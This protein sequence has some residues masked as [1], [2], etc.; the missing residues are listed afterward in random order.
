M[1]SPVAQRPAAASVSV[2][3]TPNRAVSPPPVRPTSPLPFQLRTKKK[4]IFFWLLLHI[5]FFR[6]V[7]LCFGGLRVF[8][9][10][11]CVFSSEEFSSFFFFFCDAKILT[12]NLFSVPARVASPPPAA[13]VNHTP[14]SS[15]EKEREE[16][17]RMDREIQA[18]RRAE[19]A[20]PGLVSSL[21]REFF[22]CLFCFGFFFFWFCVCVCFFFFFFER[23]NFFAVFPLFLS[24]RF[25]FFV[26]CFFFA[27]QFFEIL[28]RHFFAV[29]F[30]SHF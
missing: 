15:I 28:H 14:A 11:F 30:P 24:F 16:L 17:E 6:F 23:A 13:V 20:S 26:F 25:H 18:R 9:C 5:H 3:A 21:V 2:R 8:F 7:S 27:P 19:T 29:I 10:F 22:F 12:R 4:S 1:L